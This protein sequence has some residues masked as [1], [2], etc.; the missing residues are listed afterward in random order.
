MIYKQLYNKIKPA[1]ED[2]SEVG[3]VVRLSYIFDQMISRLEK[4][5]LIERFGQMSKEYHDLR[6]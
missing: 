2:T 3:M 5:F 1:M 6:K 4:S